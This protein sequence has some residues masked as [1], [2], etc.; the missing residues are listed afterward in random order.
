MPSCRATGCSWRVRNLIFNRVSI[1]EKLLKPQLAAAFSAVLVMLFGLALL[2]LNSRL[3]LSLRFASYDWAHDLSF[4]K[5]HPPADAGITIIYLDEASHLDFHSHST[6]RGTAPST[7]VCWTAWR[8]TAR[9]WWSSTSS[10]A[11]P[12]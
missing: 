12:A 10:S 2:N 7:R 4:V 6:G 8:R 3:S 9:R 5:L 1:K 11:T